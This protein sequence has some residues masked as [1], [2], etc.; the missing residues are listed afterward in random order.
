[1]TY[2]HAIRKNRTSRHRR[3]WQALWLVILL[4]HAPATLKALGGSWGAG[5]N[6]P[7]LFL[8]SASNLFFVLEILFSPSLHL[9]SNRR[10][11]LVFILIVALFHVGLLEHAP[12]DP[13]LSRSPQIWLL[14]TA[15]GAAGWRRMLEL[16]DRIARA[17]I[18]VAQSI[19]PM[20]A[21]YRPAPIPL[22]RRLQSPLAGYRASPLRA[23]PR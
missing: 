16:L 1:M 20:L 21:G 10:S 15:A 3:L 7:S 14:L 5:T 11:A 12:P 8:L 19:R 2:A 18:A 22:P 23:P 6:W 13:A 17:L 9:I 4:A